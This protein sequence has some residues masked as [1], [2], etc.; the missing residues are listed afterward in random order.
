MKINSEP[1]YDLEQIN[2]SSVH[3]CFNKCLEKETCAAATIK[4]L[5]VNNCVLKSSSA[6]LNPNQIDSYSIRIK[7][8]Q[9]LKIIN[10]VKFK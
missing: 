6:P 8:N 5:L 7:G 10:T 9:I 3:E 4:V 2:T 1:T